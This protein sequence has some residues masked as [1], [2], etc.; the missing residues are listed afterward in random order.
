MLNFA[1]FL[2]EI[3]AK[4]EKPE[5]G[6]NTLGVLHE[7]L[8]GYHLNGGQHMLKHNDIDGDSPKE[9][10]DKLQKMVTP[11]HY[12]EAHKRAKAAADDIRKRIGGRI[13]HVQWTSKPGDLKR[14]TG[15]EASQNEDPSDIVVTRHDDKHFGISLKKAEKTENAPIANPGMESTYGAQPILNAHRDD[16]RQNFPEV[17]NLLNSRLRKDFVRANP[18]LQTAVREK[19]R[20]TLS[21]IAS[22]MHEKLSNMSHEDLVTHLRNHVL[23]AHSTP[24][25]TQGHSHMRHT[26]WGS[27]GN[28]QT[29]AIDPGTR[30]EH[31]LNDPENI[32]VKPAG[33][34]V[35]F[36]YKDKL[37][38]KHNIKFDS[39]DDPMSSVKGATVE[40]G[41]KENPIDNHEV[42]TQKPVAAKL[43]SRGKRI[44]VSNKKRDLPKIASMPVQ[45]RAVHPDE[46]R[47]SSEGMGA[48]ITRAPK[49]KV[50]RKPRP[51]I[52]LGNDGTHGGVVF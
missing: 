8:T 11:E 20:K 47:A 9:A 45:S 52:P 37:F 43:S 46:E 28:Y 13:K 4:K 19:G 24:M 23:H 39:A 29:K 22:H 6:N 34:G 5:G 38:A 27:D 16:I 35:N 33:Q 32:E 31:I 30:Y 41:G 26:T 49:P 7:L 50:T 40:A 1:A 36:L 21:D 3:K 12:A 44:T 42:E 25:Q 15:I 48:A 18:T 2:T 51:N 10:H 14:S 17:G